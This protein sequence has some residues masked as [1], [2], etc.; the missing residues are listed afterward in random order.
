MEDNIVWLQTDQVSGDQL[1]RKL[2]ATDEF[3][4]KF[5]EVAPQ[6]F[7]NL[8]TAT[9]NNNVY[10]IEV[11]QIDNNINEL[12][13]SLYDE[14]NKQLSRTYIHKYLKKHTNGGIFFT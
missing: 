1:R 6:E 14:N 10:E 7:I 4:N 11:D 8:S 5:G 9:Y 13:I 3:K 2:I 12:G